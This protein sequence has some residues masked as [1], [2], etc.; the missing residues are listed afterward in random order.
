[1]SPPPEGSGGG[2]QAVAEGDAPLLGSD[3]K[4]PN[5]FLPAL[6]WLTI[7]SLV[8]SDM[9]QICDALQGIV[10]GAHIFTSVCIE[11]Y[12]SV[13]EEVGV[14]VSGGGTRTRIQ[15]PCSGY[16]DSQPAIYVVTDGSSSI[17]VTGLDSG[18]IRTEIDNAVIVTID[19]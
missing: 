7:S 15:L 5:A 14:T 18:G 3:L 10:D 17:D 13:G 4:I 6:S 16:I 11:G 19:E 1:M 8:A 2:G 9:E 12:T